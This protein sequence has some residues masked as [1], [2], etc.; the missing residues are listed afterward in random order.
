MPFMKLEGGEDEPIEEPTVDVL[1]VLEALDQLLR[2]QLSII[3][4]A[5]HQF[6]AISESSLPDGIEGSPD[7][8]SMTQTSPN[9]EHACLE[10]EPS[11]T[12]AV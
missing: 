1:E 10:R 11:R 3:S 2:D 7:R 8:T 12:S 6:F 9:H 5:I 4:S